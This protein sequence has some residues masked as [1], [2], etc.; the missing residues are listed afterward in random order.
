VQCWEFP[1]ENKIA[2]WNF[3]EYFYLND[4]NTLFGKK[5]IT[6]N[7]VD[8]KTELLN[9]IYRDNLRESLEKEFFETELVDSEYANK[10]SVV[11]QMIENEI[12]I[13]SD[14]GR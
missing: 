7:N 1:E 6:I 2:L 13:K 11:L 5:N 4:N 14:N 9:L 12:K 8:R 3:V 10:V